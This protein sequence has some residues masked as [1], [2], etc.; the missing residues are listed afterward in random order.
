MVQELEVDLEAFGDIFSTI[1]SSPFTVVEIDAASASALAEQLC[2]NPDDWE[3]VSP[4]AE[5][6]PGEPV[7]G[8]LIDLIRQ[9]EQAL[10]RAQRQLTNGVLEANSRLFSLVDGVDAALIELIRDELGADE[11][12]QIAEQFAAATFAAAKATEQER[13]LLLN[14]FELRARR[15]VEMRE[16]GR[17]ALAHTTSA[18]PR[19]VDRVIDVLIPRYAA[20][21]TAESPLDPELIRVF[22][23]WALEQ[24]GFQR[25]AETAYRSTGVTDLGASLT[26]LLLS[27]LEGRT[28]EYIAVRAGVS[29]DVLL[30]I[31]TKL[32]LF[33]LLTLIEQAVA[34]IQEHTTET[35]D[36]LS[37]VIAAF[38][39]YLRFGVSTPPARELM[40]RGV[41]HRA[42]AIAL[43][44]DPAMLTPTN[45]FATPRSIARDLLDDEGT[46]LPRLGALV[47]RRTVADV[48]ARR[49]A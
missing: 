48:A 47:Y 43:G 27:W 38:P 42:A 29:I 41:R 5:G 32:I 30:R 28:F 8:A 26:R 3:V 25:E 21:D 18:H 4:V 33:D 6:Q 46:W 13:A 22:V 31:H 37:P 45:I 1:Q 35:G 44:S 2:A 14:V 49:P 9:L 11:F 17:L 20:W 36:A 23:T 16:T 10:A 19:L 15:L 40:A 7:D 39:D 34:L 24:P 12:V